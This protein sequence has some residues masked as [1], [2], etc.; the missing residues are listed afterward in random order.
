MKIAL[1]LVGILL[2]ILIVVVLLPFLIDLNRYQD[3]YRPVIED[4]LNRKVELKDIRLTIV[5]R[6]GARLAG[7]TVMDDPGFSRQAFASLE[8]LD[9]GVRLL[10][11]L[12][13]RVGGEEMV[14]T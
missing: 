7:F 9:I 14:R 13:G 5:P 11:L 8:S 4:A 6:L 1:I 10:P 3:R 12:K 2:M